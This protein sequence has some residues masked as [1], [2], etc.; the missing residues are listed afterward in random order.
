MQ[1][2]VKDVAYFFSTEEQ[3]DLWFLSNMAGGM[4]I[5]WKGILFNS[6]EQLYQASKYYPDVVCLPAKHKPDTEPLVQKRILAA[7]C[8]KG[9][10]MTQKCAVDLVRLE[11]EEIMVD[12]MLWVLELKLLHNQSTFG[13]VLKSTG[14]KMIVEKSRKDTFWGCKQVGDKFEGQNHLGQLLVRLRGNYDRIVKERKLT[15]PDGFLISLQDIA[16]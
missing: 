13:K 11:W 12:C 6:S 14:D 3:P 4:R 8:A 1:Y 5:R 16:A 10:K 15:F 9:A 2:R 7:K